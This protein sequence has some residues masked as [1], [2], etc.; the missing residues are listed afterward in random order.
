M[1]HIVLIRPIP[2]AFWQIIA[3]YAKTD[4]QWLIGHI[5]KKGT[6]FSTQNSSLYNMV[7]E[8]YGQKEAAE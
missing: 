3:D 8:N 6:V 4:S 7:L 5:P 1:K 2:S